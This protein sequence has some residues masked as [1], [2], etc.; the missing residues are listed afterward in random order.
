MAAEERWG[1]RLRWSRAGSKGHT[2]TLA[3][4]VP[5]A[6]GATYAA[7]L[8]SAQ[9][10]LNATE[11]AD[12]ETLILDSIDLREE[13]VG[14]E[15]GWQYEAGYVQQDS[16]AGKDQNTTIGGTEF[17]FAI[18][19]ETQTIKEAISQTKYGAAAADH[20]NRIGVDEKGQVQGVSVAV[21]RMTYSRVEIFDVSQITGAWLDTAADSI[22]TTNAFP[23]GHQNWI[24]AN[25]GLLIGIDGRAQGDNTVRV[26]FQWAVGHRL[27]SD[28]DVAGINVSLKSAWQYV[29]IDY[30]R[31]KD[32][33][34]NLMTVRARGVYVATVYPSTDHTI[35]YRTI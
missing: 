24:E 17:S 31:Q 26:E 35:L 3:G 23:C 20:Q 6:E 11:V 14:G 28:F 19:T 22:A 21:P 30:E 7:A 2:L 16:P 25:R 15:P 12:G 9:A 27:K 32:A 10:A 4:I 33:A 18:G 34:A 29:W 8:A 13:L 1:R 5:T